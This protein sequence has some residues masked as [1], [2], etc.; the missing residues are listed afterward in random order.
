MDA[1]DG[2][3]VL[4]FTVMLFVIER[5]FLERVLVRLAASAP[6]STYRV[7]EWLHRLLLSLSL[8]TVARA[9]AGSI[10]VDSFSW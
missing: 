8:L 9:V 5:L 2:P 3:D 1:R 10:G 7:V 4:A 6:E